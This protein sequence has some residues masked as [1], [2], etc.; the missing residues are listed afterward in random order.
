MTIPLEYREL[1]MNQEHCGRFPYEHNSDLMPTDHPVNI[2]HS[3]ARS[4]VCG[5]CG[6]QTSTWTLFA[7]DDGTDAE[8][9]VH[10]PRCKNCT[11]I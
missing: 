6:T 4:R 7:S 1:T 5:V 8:L 10:C 11:Q 2:C 9:W 3:L